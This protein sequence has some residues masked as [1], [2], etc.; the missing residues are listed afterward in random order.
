MSVMPDWQQLGVQLQLLEEYNAPKLNIIDK[1]NSEDFEAS[2]MSEYW[3]ELTSALE[4]NTLATNI[5]QNILKGKYNFIIML[6]LI[7]RLLA[8]L[9][10]VMSL[11]WLDGQ[12]F[13]SV[14]DH[15]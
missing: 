3:Y 1:N 6:L 4:L 7:F 9:C 15:L 2:K 14:I 11:D 12:A 13:P 10:Y 5:Q 8:K